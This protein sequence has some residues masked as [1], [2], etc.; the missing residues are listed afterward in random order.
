MVNS[1]ATES[2]FN[3][4]LFVCNNTGQDYFTGTT[5]GRTICYEDIAVE[6]VLFVWILLFAFVESCRRAPDEYVEEFVDECAAERAAEGY[7]SLKQLDDRR[8]AFHRRMSGDSCTLT[9]TM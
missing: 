1:S 9:W 6:T 2:F 7:S 8:R 4:L 5:E 3:A